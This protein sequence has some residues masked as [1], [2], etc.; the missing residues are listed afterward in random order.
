M[1]GLLRCIFFNIVRYG[2]SNLPTDLYGVSTLEYGDTFLL[3]GGVCNSACFPYV[4]SDEILKFDPETET[5]PALGK[6][7]PV[8]RANHG[9]VLVGED[10]VDCA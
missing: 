1:Y 8:G 4:Y 2:K 9:A 3:I 5:W 7:L 10:V 6:K